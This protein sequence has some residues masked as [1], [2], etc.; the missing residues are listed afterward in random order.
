MANRTVIGTFEGQPVEEIELRSAFGAV[1]RIMTWGAVVRDLQVPHRG[2]LQRVVLGFED[3]EHYPQHS[4]H[5]GAIAGRFANR[6]NRGSFK[7]DG[8]RVQLTLNQ[9]DPPGPGGT[10]IGRASCRER[11]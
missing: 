7:L 11:V 10:Q 9:N 3:F 1:A 2:T 5:F 4:P 6:I 8:K